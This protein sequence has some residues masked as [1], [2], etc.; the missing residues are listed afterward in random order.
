MLSKN[1]YPKNNAYFSNTN[2]CIMRVKALLLSILLISTMSFR[3]MADEGMW[4]PLLLESLNQKEMQALGFKLTAEDIYSINHG[5][6]KDAVVLFGRGCTAEIVSDQGLIFTNHH[7]GYGQ[8]QSHSTVEHDYLTDGFWAMSKEQELSCPGLTA[9]ILVYMEDVTA[10]VL[11]KLN[12]KMTEKNVLKLNRAGEKLQPRLFRN[13]LS[14][15][16]KIFL[17]GNEFYLMFMKLNMFVL[18]VRHLHGNLEATRI[19]GAGPVIRD[20]SVFRI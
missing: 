9:T 3:S 5:S 8:I 4:L 1:L 14:G 2:F 20:F 18:L 12:D 13:T 16:G 6:M 17:Y 7:C 11:A 19:I 15:S 10:K